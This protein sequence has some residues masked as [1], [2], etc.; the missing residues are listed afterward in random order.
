MLEV[1]QVRPCC[2]MLTEEAVH[3]E[4]TQPAEQGTF[5]DEHH[6][7]GHLDCTEWTLEVEAWQQLRKQAISSYLLVER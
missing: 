5:E 1:G 4:Q 2:C 7:A 6:S 3:K